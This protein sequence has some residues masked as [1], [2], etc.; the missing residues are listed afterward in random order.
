[1]HESKTYVFVEDQKE[2]TNYNGY[3]KDDP[4]ISGRYSIVGSMSVEQRNVLLFFWTSIKCLPV[5]GFGRLDSK[6]HIYRT[7]DSYDC[8]PSSHTCFYHLCF[9]PYLSMDV[10]QNC[11]NII[12]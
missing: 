6:L 2:H 8:L 10:M 5:K 9:P 7:L 12:T 1:I 4:Q 3:K 11:L